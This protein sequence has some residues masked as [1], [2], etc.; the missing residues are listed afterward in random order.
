MNI[1]SSIS[2]TFMIQKKLNLIQGYGDRTTS[3]DN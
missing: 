1:K 3:I 2:I